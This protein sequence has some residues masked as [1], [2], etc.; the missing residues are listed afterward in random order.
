MHHCRLPIRLA[1]ISRLVNTLAPFVSISTSLVSF[2][3]NHPLSSL[4]FSIIV[5]TQ[6]LPHYSSRHCMKPPVSP[7]LHLFLSLSLFLTSSPYHSFTEYC[8]Q[9]SLALR[10]H[11]CWLQY[12]L[13]FTIHHYKPYCVVIGKFLNLNLS[14]V[15]PLSF[16]PLS[17]SLTHLSFPS[18]DDLSLSLSRF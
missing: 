3:H 5:T 16:F 4:W 1:L 13:S 2:S 10:A 8:Y 6:A 9:L 7:I 17:L 18:I 14:V 12:H 15:P 11:H